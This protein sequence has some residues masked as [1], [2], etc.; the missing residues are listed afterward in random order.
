MSENPFVILVADR[1]PS[2]EVVAAR[3]LSSALETE[4]TVFPTRV[5]VL[6][7]PSELKIIDEPQ[8]PPSVKAISQRVVSAEQ[9]DI[10]LARL[11]VGFSGLDGAKVN[12]VRDAGVAA[13]AVNLCQFVLNLESVSDEFKTQD[14]IDVRDVIVGAALQFGFG[15]GSSQCE[16]C[17]DKVGDSIDYW[18]NIADTCARFAQTV[19]KLQS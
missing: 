9:S 6:A 17:A 13:P 18:I 7:S 14:A 3:L 11:I 4:Y 15:G 16:I 10:A 19:G 1:D 12:S 5:R 2:V 8:L